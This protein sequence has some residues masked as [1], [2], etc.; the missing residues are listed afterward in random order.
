MSTPAMLRHVASWP[1]RLFAL[2][3]LTLLCGVFVLAQS[4]IYQRTFLVSVNE[5]KAAVQAA[6]ATS[7]GRL[8][9]LEGFVEQ[10]EQPIERYEKGYFECTYQISPAAGGGTVIRASAKVTAWYSDPLAAR[11]GYRVMISNGRLETDALDRIAES[12]TPNSTP[13][14]AKSPAPPPPG[15]FRRSAQPVLSAPG[16]AANTSRSASTVS[17]PHSTIAPAFSLPAGADFDSIKTLRTADEKK[18][19]ELATLIS[20]LEEIQRAQSH[21]NDLAAVK[22][23]K[24]PVLAKPAESSQVLMTAEAQDEFQILAVENVWVHVQISG[25]SRGWI[26]R[27]QLEMPPSFAQGV[28]SNSAENSSGDNAMFK[29]AKEETRSFSGNWPALKGK[30]VQIEWVEPANPAVATSRQEKL[31]FAKSVFLHASASLPSSPQNTEGIVVV[32]DS[33]DGGQIAASL[34]SVKALANRTL[35]DS[36]FW[37]ECSLDPPESFLDSVKQ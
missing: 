12:L 11:S 9:T 13:A 32:F 28:G 27:S 22:K 2:F 16:I 26:R 7:K 15:D 35:T 21:P 34:S 25:M 37:R 29:V 30:P 10:N 19:Q 17:T 23:S 33:S 8:P 36:A 3:H 24:T 6:S 20:N 4:D 31:A 18:S 14:Q 1:L 5:A